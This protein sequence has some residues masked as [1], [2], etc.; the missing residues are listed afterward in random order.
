MPQKKIYKSKPRF[1]VGDKVKFNYVEI[2]VTT[3]ISEDR[4]NLGSRGQRVYGLWFTLPYSEPAYIELP[5]EEL[6]P[7]S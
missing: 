3:E 4:G 5:E 7:A 6:E 1:R 2:P